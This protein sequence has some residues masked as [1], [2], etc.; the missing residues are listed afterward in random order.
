ML[1][2]L[3]IGGTLIYVFIIIYLVCRNTMP[4]LKDVQEDDNG[5]L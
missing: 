2:K 3:I 1:I 4:G 5:I